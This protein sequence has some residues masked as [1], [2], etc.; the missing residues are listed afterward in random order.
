MIVWFVDVHSFDSTLHSSVL[1]WSSKI[2]H[3]FLWILFVMYML[4]MIWVI[5]VRMLSHC[6]GTV[7]MREESGCR[8]RKWEEM[9][10]KKAAEDGE[11]EQQWL[12]MEDCT[13]DE[14]QQQEWSPETAY[15]GDCIWWMYTITIYDCNGLTGGR[16]VDVNLFCLFCGLHCQ[17]KLLQTSS[18]AARGPPR[19]AYNRQNSTWALLVQLIIQYYLCW[20]A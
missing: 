17:H 14:W 3:C 19:S 15:G 12:V 8:I 13:T 5:M 6:V 20:R 10:F 1:P 7:Q 11:G 9:W 16:I 18:V 4:C 2:V